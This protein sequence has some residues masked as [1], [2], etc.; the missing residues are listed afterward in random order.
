MV[1]WQSTAVLPE[2]RLQ[3]LRAPMGARARLVP[4]HPE[5]ILRPPSI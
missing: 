3:S 1:R 4:A 2:F 5:A